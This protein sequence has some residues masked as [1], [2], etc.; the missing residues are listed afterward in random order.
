[1]ITERFS[2]ANA[3]LA[4]INPATYSAEQNTAWLDMSKYERIVVVLNAG[5]IGTSLD[6]D[7]EIATD[8]SGSN[9]HTLKSITQLTEAGGDDNANVVIEI[10]AS[11][12]TSPSGADSTNYRYVKVEVTPSGNCIFGVMVYGNEA[13]YEA[14]ATTNWDEIVAS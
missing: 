2:E 3:L 6:I 14:V 8:S 11:E 10:R 12:M 4:T 9:I 5:D 13:R 1:M 7:I